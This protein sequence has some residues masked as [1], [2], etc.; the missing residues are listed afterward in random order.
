[1]S[2]ALVTGGTGFLGANLAAELLRRGWQV[3]ILRRTTSPLAA[4]NDLNVEH[5]LGD[6]LDPDSLSAVMCGVDIVFHVAAI[7]I[8]WRNKPETI[9]KVNVEGT[10]NVLDAAKRLGIRRVVFTSS[11][12]AIGIVRGRPSTE[13]DPYHEQIVHFPYGHSKWLAEEIAREAAQAGQDVTIV[14]PS[15]I[16]GPRDLNWGAGSIIKEVAAR[17][18]PAVPPG[19]VNYVAVEDVVAGHIA[20]A[21]R[22]RPGERYLLTGENLTHRQLMETVARVVGVKPPRFN[23]PRRA[24][25]ALAFAAAVAKRMGLALPIDAAQL[26]FSREFIWFDNSKAR[27]ELGLPHTPI[28]QAVREA[29]RWYV[30]NGYL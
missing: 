3:R 12:A 11:A 9:Y 17:R 18:V 16:V 7:S 20:A 29:Y 19:G 10:R 4:V 8:Y 13:D 21:E 24:I 1:M 6:V 26:R 28:E 2:T 5:A 30:E 14:N 22:G 15:V 27:R 25:P 23:L